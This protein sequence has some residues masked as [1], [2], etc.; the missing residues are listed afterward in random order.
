MSEECGE[1]WSARLDSIIA[2]TE[3]RLRAIALVN[4]RLAPRVQQLGGG[5]PDQSNR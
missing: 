5:E 3:E 1:E 2:A 4:A